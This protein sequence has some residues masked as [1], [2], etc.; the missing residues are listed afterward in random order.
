M[1]VMA[2][3][4]AGALVGIALMM[5]GV[6]A[7]C[8]SGALNAQVN[9]FHDETET[10]VKAQGEH[11]SALGAAD[12]ERIRRQLVNN[13]VRLSLSDECADLMQPVSPPRR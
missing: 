13:R 2:L 7:G 5:A 9:A 3:L 10:L 4:R 8:A 12:A 11:V 1:R 6:L